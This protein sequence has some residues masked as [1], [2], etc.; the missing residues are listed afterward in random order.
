MKFGK[1]ILASLNLFSVF[2]GPSSSHSDNATT[3]SIDESKCQVCN[4][5][6]A[7]FKELRNYK[8]E[9]KYVVVK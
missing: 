2:L 7:A 8:I 3:V 1:K 9:F 5:V 6:S 4:E